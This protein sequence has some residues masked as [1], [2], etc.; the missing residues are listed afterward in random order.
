MSEPLDDPQNPA[1]MSPHQR[2]NEIAAILA[3]GV[4]RLRE[5]VHL[6]PGS[7]TSRTAEKSLELRVKSLDPDAKARPHVITE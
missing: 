4:L 5:M 1:T 6:S 3:H 7:S 2:R